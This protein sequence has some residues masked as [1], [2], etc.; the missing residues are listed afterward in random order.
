V[1]T[2]ALDNGF[3]DEEAVLAFVN[4]HGYSHGPDRFADAEGLVAWLEEVA[5]LGAVPGEARVTD[6]DAAEARG[7]RDALLDALLAHAR[8]PHTD[9]ARV[10]AS[11]VALRR[12][13]ERYPLSAKVDGDGARLRPARGGLAGVLGQVLASVAT[14]SLAGEWPRLKACRFEPCHRAFVDST[15]N[16]SAAYC[17]SK[18]SSRATM[19]AYRARRRAASTGAGDDA[20]D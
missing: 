20:T 11:A 7:L 4:S 9:A 2:A 8:D 14:L 3:G 5:W 16:R 15:R 6:A 18:C 13:G 10:E 19:R 12:A 17:R 1:D